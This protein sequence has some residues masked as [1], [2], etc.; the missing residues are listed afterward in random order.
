MRRCGGW[1]EDN[2][3]P[4]WDFVNS[5]KFTGC[6]R[7]VFKI[8]KSNMRNQTNPEFAEFIITLLNI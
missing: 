3:Y 2:Y 1:C 8:K 4:G 6:S 7:L 5:Y